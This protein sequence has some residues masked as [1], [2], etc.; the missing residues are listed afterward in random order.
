MAIDL[1]EQHDQERREEAARAYR[2]APEFPALEAEAARR[3]YR[4]ATISEINAS[5]NSARF[6]IDLFCWRGGLWVAT[7]ESLPSM[8]HCE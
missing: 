3:G 6:A 8:P 5:A 1:Y 2:E 4:K 7:G